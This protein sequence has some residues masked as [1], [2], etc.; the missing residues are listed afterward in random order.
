MS[1]LQIVLLLSRQS[2]QPCGLTPWVRQV[3]AAA[4]WAHEHRLRV[5]TSIGMPTWELVCAAA[6]LYRLRQTVLV[7]AADAADYHQSVE[8]CRTEFCLEPELVDFVPVYT[9]GH[10]P[11]RAALMSARDDAIVTRA[12]VLVP[13]SLRPRGRLEELLKSAAAGA[14]VVERFR[15]PYE[16]RREQLNYRLDDSHTNPELESLGD[17]YLFHWTRAVNHCW[18]DESPLAYYA[19][20]LTSTVYPRRAVDTLLHILTKDKIIASTRHMP[21]GAAVVSFSGLPPA[22]ALPLMRWRARYGEMSFE[23][24][25]VGIDR[26]CAEAAG[27]VPVRYFDRAGDEMPENDERWRRQS[28]GVRTD[29]RREQEYRHRGNLRLSSVPIE[30]LV[31]VCRYPAEAKKITALT[32]VRTVPILADN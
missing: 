14:R 13:L 19:S 5:L 23:P 21:T 32:G 3:Q 9:D 29:W 1:T 2:R 16:R 7:P 12:D 18:P 24:Y 6:A 28:N 8:H 22:G 27:I 10:R 20:I 30:A 31:A 11:T 15:I 4:G 25:G 26:R 17:R